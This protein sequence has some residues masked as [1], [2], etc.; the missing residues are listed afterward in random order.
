[1]EYCDYSSD[2][3]SFQIEMFDNIQS[4][5]NTNNRTQFV[6]CINEFDCRENRAIMEE[7]RSM[8][9][10]ATKKFPLLFYGMQR[11][12][13]RAHHSVIDVICNTLGIHIF[14]AMNNPT[15]ENIKFIKDA[16]QNI[17]TICNQNP[18]GF[19][20]DTGKLVL[21]C[22]FEKY[23]EINKIDAANT[24]MPISVA[25]LIKKITDW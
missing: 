25:E 14:D 18:W 12:G 8:L 11:P 15:D 6:D 24:T 13:T 9:L 19:K 23:L 4:N 1:M 16:F 2:E 7:D 17:M 5:Y 3:E 22:I 10:R 20:L 21:A